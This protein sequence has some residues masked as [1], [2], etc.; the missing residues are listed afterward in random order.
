VYRRNLGI[1]GPEHPVARGDH[2]RLPP[3]H[4]PLIPVEHRSMRAEVE[5]VLGEEDARAEASRCLH[6]WVAPTFGANPSRGNECIACGGCADVC[7]ENCI[8]LVPVA[9]PSKIRAVALVMDEAACIRCGLCSRRCPTGVI[10]M[11][12]CYPHG[13]VDLVRLADPVL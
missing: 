6:C 13:E 9:Q 4:V 10:S 7:P 2:E 5:A 12:A 11:T 8:Q 3:R 1:A